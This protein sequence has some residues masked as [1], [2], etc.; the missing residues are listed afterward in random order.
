MQS[1]LRTK[2]DKLRGQISEAEK[3]RSNTDRRGAAARATVAK[4]LTQADKDAFD[5][6][7]TLLASKITELK[8]MDARVALGEE[9]LVAL[10]DHNASNLSLNSS[11]S[12][13][14]DSVN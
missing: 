2:R 13:L 8:E 10:E 1:S 9:Q 4:H 7:L 5:A 6:F 14:S 3:L 12:S 11:L